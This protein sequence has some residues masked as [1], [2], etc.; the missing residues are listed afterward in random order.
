MHPSSFKGSEYKLHDATNEHR[1]QNLMLVEWQS[2]QKPLCKSLSSRDR[3]GSVRACNMTG[4]QLAG[5]TVH[6]LSMR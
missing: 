4:G 1:E 5:H 6:L 2:V 3:I